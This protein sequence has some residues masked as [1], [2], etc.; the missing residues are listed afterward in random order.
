MAKFAHPRKQAISVIKHLQ[1]TVIKSVGSVRIYEGALTQIA[2]SSFLKLRGLSLRDLTEEEAHAYL[3]WRARHVRQ[4][5]L[6]QERLAIQMMLRNVS[7]KLRANDKLLLVHSHQPTHKTSR[8]YSYREVRQVAQA[9]RDNN[10]LCTWLA[11]HAGLRA[12]ELMTLRPH[13][14]CPPDHRPALPSKFLGR[15]GALYTVTGKGG[16]RRTVLVSHH[17]QEALEIRRMKQ[18]Q[19]VQDREVFYLPYYNIGGGNA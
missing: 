14:E 12:H 4:A 10:Q 19:Q 6:N 7:H 13:E 2:G 8:S 11:Y 15:S 1:G 3:T 16:L 5:T 9:Q 17:L 18:P